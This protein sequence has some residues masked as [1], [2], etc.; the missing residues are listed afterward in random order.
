[1]CTMIRM[2]HRPTIT[3]RKHLILTGQQLKCVPMTQ[4][5]S[6]QGNYGEITCFFLRILNKYI[7]ILS[8]T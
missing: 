3:K 8:M 4:M 7:V 6:C 5:L 1:M 2:I